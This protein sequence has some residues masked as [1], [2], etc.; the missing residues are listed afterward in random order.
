MLDLWWCRLRRSRLLVALAAVAMLLGSG[1]AGVTYWRKAQEEQALAARLNR[2][3]EDLAQEVAQAPAKPKQP[4]AA[5]RPYWQALAL[6]KRLVTDQ[7]HAASALEVRDYRGF[8]RN[9]AAALTTTLALEKVQPGS[10]LALTQTTLAALKSRRRRAL[11]VAASGQTLI[12][13][14][15]SLA[16]RA[17]AARCLA[18]LAWAPVVVFVAIGAGALWREL[19]DTPAWR[20]QLLTTRRRLHLQA[21]DLG[22]GVSLLTG[23]AAVAVGVAALWGLVLGGGEVVSW[24]YPLSNDLTLGHQWLTQLA[25]WL[26]LAVLA[27]SWCQLG[28]L[29]VRQLSGRLALLLAVAAAAGVV[30]GDANPLGQL[31][32]IVLAPARTAARWPVVVLLGLAALVAAGS[33]WRLRTARGS[34]TA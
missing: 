23:F 21:V 28:T 31:Q 11:K 26:P 5:E 7:H 15:W 10:G 34:R 9:Y 4:K 3:V 1:V 12:W 27:V 13:S 17:L 30:P 24:R 2:Q 33:L 19:F 14:T 22:V 29:A 8:T 6:K 18:F 16:P 25:Y 32:G 20:F